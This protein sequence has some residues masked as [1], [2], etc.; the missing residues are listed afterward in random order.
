MCHRYY[1]DKLRFKQDFEFYQLFTTSLC[2]ACHL[3]AGSCFAVCQPVALAYT[4]SSFSLAK[5][6]VTQA[7]PWRAARLGAGLAAGLL[8]GGLS[9]CLAVAGWLAR[10]D[11]GLAGW[12]LAE[13]YT[14]ATTTNTTFLSSARRELSIAPV[15]CKKSY[16]LRAFIIFEGFIIFLAKSH[17][18]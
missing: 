13:A 4:C 17:P 7:R 2:P 11:L 5:Q 12:L 18:F 9:A 10:W 16:H 15:L 8:A 1:Q 6:R 3:P 14:V